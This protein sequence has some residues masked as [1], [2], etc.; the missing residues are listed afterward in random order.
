VRCEWPRKKQ[1]PTAPS[2]SSRRRSP[3]SCA[4][5]PRPTN[6]KTSSS[7]TRGDELPETLAS[8]AGRLAKL[9]QA[10]A[11]L[12]AD[13]AELTQDANDLQQLDPML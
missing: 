3:S 11:R 2:T 6:T 4:R 1:G 5:Q 13:A 12:E 9:R 8:K 7:A 10:K